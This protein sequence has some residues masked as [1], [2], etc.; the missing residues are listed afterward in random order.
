MFL[1][2]LRH[3][4]Y[5]FI[6]SSTPVPDRSTPPAVREWLPQGT[7]QWPARESMSLARQHPSPSYR[8]GDSLLFPIRTRV[9]GSATG[10]F[11]SSIALISVK[12]DALAPIPKASVSMA[13]E[14][15]IV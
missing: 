12:I 1:A 2:E 8:S 10:R 5:A 6:Q 11:L 4:E 9:C 15:G 7:Q 14:A 13:G 3:S